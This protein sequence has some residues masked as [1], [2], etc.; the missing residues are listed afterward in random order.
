MAFDE[1]D[2]LFGL[3]SGARGLEAGVGGLRAVGAVTVGEGDAGEGG[4]GAGVGVS[5]VMGDWR[6]HCR[7]VSGRAGFGVA[8]VLLA[9]LHCSSLGG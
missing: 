6:G 8:S 7:W 5:L 4:L 9:V 3:C 1:A 2:R